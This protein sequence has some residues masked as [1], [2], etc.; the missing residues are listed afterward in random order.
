LGAFANSGG[1][2]LFLRG[3]CECSP[4]VLS[5]N[6]HR[7]ETAASSRRF[8]AG[9]LRPDSFLAA[10][11]A[12]FA[13]SS[14]VARSRIVVLAA[15]AFA[16]TAGTAHAGPC[17]TQIAE[18]EQYI[19]RVAKRQARGPT[20]LQSIGAQLHHQPTPQSVE[21]GVSMARADAEA[22]LDR[23]RRA[24]VEDNIAACT[25]AL[26]EAKLIYGLE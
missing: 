16:G 23:A 19:G 14:L 25:K 4:R 15:L 6:R 21:R 11:A 18:V 17:T 9:L 5:C 26:D 22:V 20:A 8:A 13:E 12:T 2:I 3:G 1:A 10:S 7:I 24:D